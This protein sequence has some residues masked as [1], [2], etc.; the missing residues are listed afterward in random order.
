MSEIKLI[1]TD[2][3]RMAEVLR[4]RDHIDYQCYMELKELVGFFSGMVAW[5]SFGQDEQADVQNCLECAQKLT[6]QREAINSVF[7]DMASGRPV[8]DHIIDSA[9]HGED[10]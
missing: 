8:P 1:H 3:P 9:I 2:H 10:E 4:A 5:D 7:C 6:R